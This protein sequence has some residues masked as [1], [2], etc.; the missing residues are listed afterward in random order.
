MIDNDAKINKSNKEMI[1]LLLHIFL[2]NMLLN[3]FEMPYLIPHL[4]RRIKE[5]MRHELKLSKDFV[6]GIAK[7][8]GIEDTKNKTPS[9]RG[10]NIR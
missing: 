8:S 7:N 5:K 2:E 10:V 3:I 4:N 6:I 1:I 9:S